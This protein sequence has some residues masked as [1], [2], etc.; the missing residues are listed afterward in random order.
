MNKLYIV[1]L[2]MDGSGADFLTQSIKERDAKALEYWQSLVD[3]RQPG[4]VTVREDIVDDDRYKEAMNEDS[5]YF[6]TLDWDN[7]KVLFQKE[8][9]PHMMKSKVDLQKQIQRIEAVHKDH[10]LYNKA[11]NKVIFYNHN[12]SMSAENQRYWKEWM[13]LNRDP[14]KKEQA[15]ALLKKMGDEPYHRNLYTARNNQ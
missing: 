8:Y 7:T 1:S 12:M 9:H 11:L 4:S 10:R 15:D 3:N 13:R 6:D 14:E 2:D 5:Y